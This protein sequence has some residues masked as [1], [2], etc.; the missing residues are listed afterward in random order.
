MR[1]SSRSAERH[2]HPHSARILAYIL[3]YSLTKFILKHISIWTLSN[4]E[5][6]LTSSATYIHR[7][8]S[9]AWEIC[10]LRDAAMV[11]GCLTSLVGDNHQCHADQIHRICHRT[12]EV[13]VEICKCTKPLQ[14]SDV[15]MSISYLLHFIMFIKCILVMVV[16]MLSLSLTPYNTHSHKTHMHTG[17][18]L[19]RPLLASRPDLELGVTATYPSCSPSHMPLSSIAW[20]RNVTS[21]FFRCRSTITEFRNSI[22]TKHCRK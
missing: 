6:N 9:R 18:L 17:F 15:C 1:Q 8:H 13:L 4:A 12:G 5:R 7:S 2:R 19:Q 10:G 14:K 11:V 16:H 21:W 3:F 22:C 20:R